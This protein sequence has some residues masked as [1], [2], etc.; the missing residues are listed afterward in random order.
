[1]VSLGTDSARV[2]MGASGTDVQP[3]P[4]AVAPSAQ[5]KPLSSM[6]RAEKNALGLDYFLAE[7]N[8][9]P[10]LPNANPV[11]C[12]SIA[13]LIE[14]YGC[15]TVVDG[16][17]LTQSRF[18]TNDSDPWTFVYNGRIYE[19]DPYRFPE[20]GELMHASHPEEE[21]QSTHASR[22]GIDT[23]NFEHAAGSGK[24]IDPLLQQRI[25]ALA[26]EAKGILKPSIPEMR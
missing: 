21:F 4:Q 20:Y 11:L 24:A 14:T 22:Q 12:L 15:G 6:T 10:N 16:S 13:V 23:D 19:F 1:M 8:S 26:E 5:G 7:F 2:P 3:E 18:R 17:K 9:T 25:L